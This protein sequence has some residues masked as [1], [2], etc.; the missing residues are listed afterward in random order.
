V[1]IVTATGMQT[2]IGRVAGMLETAGGQE[3]PLQR[4]IGQLAR[5]LSVV[6]G[7][8]VVVVVVLG[9]LRG[10]PFSELLLTSVSLAVATIPEGLTAVVA[11]TLA[12]GARRLASR[13]AILKD[14]ASVETLGSTSHIATDK[15][16]TLTLNQMT[17]RTL[18]AVGHQFTVTGEGYRTDGTLEIDDDGPMPT[19]ALLAMALASDAVAR[20]GELVGDPTEGALVVLAEKGGLDV[21]DARRRWPRLAEVPFDSSR[22]YMATLHRLSDSEPTPAEDLAAPPDRTDDVIVLFAKGAPDVL[23]ARSDRILTDEGWVELDAS[24]VERLREVNAGLASEGMRVMAVAARGFT[25]A[26]LDVGALT[27]MEPEEIDA[28]VT[29]LTMLALVGIVDPPRPEAMDAVAEAQAAGISVHM[30]TGDHVGTASAIAQRLGIDGDAVLGSEVDEIDDEELASRARHLGVLARVS[31]EHKIRMVG[32]LRADGSVVAMTGDGVNDA[33][34][35]KQADIGIAMGITGTDVSKGAARM[36]LTD[37]NFATIVVAVREGRGI[38]DNI[39]QFIRFQIA[40]AWGF[41]VIFLTAGLFGLAGGVPF[42]ALQI[43]WV[44]I[45]M[46]GPPAMALGLDD[47][48]PDV[49]RRSPRP[50]HEPILTPARVV[51][52]LLAAAVMAGGTLGILTLAPGA[53]AEVA[54]LAFTTYVLF[55]VFNLLNVRS[56]DTSVF[57]PRTFTNRWLWTAMGAVVVLQMA[58]VHLPVLQDLFDTNALDAGQWLLA[59]TISS[60]V[61][62]VEELRKAV[63]RRHAAQRSGLTR[64]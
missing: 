19:A 27:H 41:V 1:C 29:G 57:S 14:L 22:K 13:G 15:T 62:W 20:D 33:P 34:A 52:I 55:Q 21:R 64:Q 9:L 2:E 58:V 26:D 59:V 23:A 30:I 43:L 10:V 31:P 42:T 18:F 50:V 47:P 3:T 8:V 5:M 51:R 12:M 24:D 35:L 46:D 54:T 16:G 11:F 32:A 25:E 60:S 28:L 40:T 45:I 48:A 39:L 6:A 38:Y 37:D 49:M 36:I 7:V 17:A 56:A 63:M 61:I 44:N 4:R 53:N